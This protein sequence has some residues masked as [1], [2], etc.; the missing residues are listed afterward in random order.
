MGKEIFV[1]KPW[2][3]VPM[4]AL[5]DEPGTSAYYK[6]GSWRSQRP[7]WDGQRCVHC[8]ICW[9]YCPDSAIR[10]REGKVVG[11]DYDY[12]KGCGICARECP[13]KAGAIEMVGGEDGASG[14]S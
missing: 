9:V 7:V 3:R 13:P 10:V 12:C 2:Q 8:F 14:A 6:T 5:I 1:L 4:S 11:I